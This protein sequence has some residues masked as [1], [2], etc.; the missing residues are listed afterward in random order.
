MTSILYVS[1]PCAVDLDETELSE[2]DC[3]SLTDADVC[4]LLASLDPFQAAVAQA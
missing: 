3:E 4:T 2:L 1:E